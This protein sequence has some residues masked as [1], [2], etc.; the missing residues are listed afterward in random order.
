MKSLR[1]LLLTVL[2]LGLVT[3]S[4]GQIMSTNWQFTV[5]DGNMPGYFSTDNDD[6][7]GIA[8]YD[9]KVYLGSFRANGVKILD[10]ASGDSIGMVTES[11]VSLGDVNVDNDGVLFGSKMVGHEG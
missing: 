4:M 3:V 5:N 8:A 1:H 11:A 10:I 6:I 9:G 7:R 2:L